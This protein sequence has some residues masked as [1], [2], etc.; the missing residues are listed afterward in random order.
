MTTDSLAIRT[1]EGV[2][3]SMPLAD[4]VNRCAAWTLDVLTVGVVFSVMSWVLLLFS[5]ISEDLAG[6]LNILLGFVLL[7]CYNIVCEWY[8]RG[9][10][11]GKRVM[12]LRVVDV[13]G[14]RLAFPQI[15]A[16]NL[17]RVVDAM[18]VSYCV[19]GLFCALS[20][21]C[22]RLGDIAAGT[23]VISLRKA[24]AVDAGG[25]PWNKYNSLRGAAVQV[26]RLRQNISTEEV[27]MA[28]HALIRRD[29]LEPGAR[30]ALFR[31]MADHFR[32]IASF[33][34]DMM[35]ELS[36]EQF[37]RNAVEVMCGGERA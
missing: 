32:S 16:R 6:S 20:P 10:T 4:P 26:A 28:L 35:A 13:E 17:L 27:E 23:A 18:P 29:C 21:L 19:G 37:V 3:F 11:V 15:M 34:P 12:R 24:R 36:A 25:M 33:P 30:I 7:I 2:L 31:E 22:Q 1:R 5:L 9:Q 14:R 8:W